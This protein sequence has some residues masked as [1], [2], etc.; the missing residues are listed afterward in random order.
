MIIKY[1]SYII[2]KKYNTRHKFVTDDL[3]VLENR[4]YELERKYILQFLT[5]NPNANE[6]RLERAVFRGS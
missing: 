3:T 6:F 1:L 5:V 2:F 4:K